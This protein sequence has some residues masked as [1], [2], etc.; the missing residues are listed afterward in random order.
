MSNDLHQLL[1]AHTAM[2]YSYAVVVNHLVVL[3]LEMVNVHLDISAW[4]VMFAAVVQLVQA[5]A[6][7]HQVAMQ[8]V[9]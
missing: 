2:E 5:Q 4:L 1:L 8:S 3:A 6:H 7:V 9:P